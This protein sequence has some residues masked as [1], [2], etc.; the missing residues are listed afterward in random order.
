M[1]EPTKSTDLAWQE[2]SDEV[3][4][5]ADAGEE[6]TLW[7]RDDDAIEPTKQLTRLT[8][9]VGQFKIP[10]SLAVIPESASADLAGEVSACATDT[11]L[12][13]HGLGHKNH[14]APGEKKAEFCGQ[15]PSAE[16]TTDI[17]RAWRLL[18][19]KFAG[20]AL[21]VLV[22][23]WNRIPDE[24]V[25]Q[26]P[27]L[28]IKGL[29]TYKARDLTNTPSDLHINNC[30][31]DPI[32]WKSGK[33]FLGEAQTLGLLTEHLS[34][35]RTNSDDPEAISG[36]ITGILTHHLVQDAKTWAFLD[37]FAAWT[38]EQPTVRWLDAFE[39]FKLR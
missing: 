10:L 37:K 1:T 23:P 11:C 8:D 27:G 16:M 33:T 20:R 34:A 9:L 32:N 13:V 26:L 28:G 30:H 39:V 5:W 21:P 31:I 2:L 14:A 19:D 6:V 12:L 15:R 29:S 36:E 25:S 17:G 3:G 38:A 22:P 7:W 35:R 24:I 4:L 18:E